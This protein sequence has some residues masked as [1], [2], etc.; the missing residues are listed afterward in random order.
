[1]LTID[2]CLS[3]MTLKSFLRESGD[4]LVYKSDIH[5]IVVGFAVFYVYLFPLKEY[6]FFFLSPQK[7]SKKNPK[8]L[9]KVLK[10]EGSYLS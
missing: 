5:F 9:G 1:M 8:H 4:L 2:I 3:R 7:S 6:V 10:T